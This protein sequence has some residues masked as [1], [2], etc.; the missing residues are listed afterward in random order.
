MF[1]YTGC[2]FLTDVHSDKNSFRFGAV[3]FCCVGWGLLEDAPAQRNQ[4]CPQHNAEAVAAI[5]VENRGPVDIPPRQVFGFAKLEVAFRRLTNEKC[6]D[7]WHEDD[8]G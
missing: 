1:F 3:F 5:W 7:F 2:F 6:K 4:V 8:R